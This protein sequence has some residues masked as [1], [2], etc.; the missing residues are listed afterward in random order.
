MK[1]PTKIEILLDSHR[2]IYIPRDFAIECG[3]FWNIPQ[4]SLDILMNPD[5]EWYWE[6]WETILNSAS[7]PLDG[8]TYTLHHDGDLFAVRDDL[9]DEEKLEFYGEY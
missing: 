4:K 5:H 8:H 2:G 7:L 1:R 3:D 9:T 6:E